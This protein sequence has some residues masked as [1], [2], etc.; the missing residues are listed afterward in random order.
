MLTGYYIKNT[1]PNSCT[2]IYLSQADPKGQSISKARFL[3]IFHFGHVSQS[4]FCLQ[5]LSQSGW[6]TKRLRSLL[7]GYVSFPCRNV[8]VRCGGLGVCSPVEFRAHATGVSK[9]SNAS[10][11]IVSTE[12][13]NWSCWQS[14]ISV[15]AD[16]VLLVE[17]VFQ[18]TL[19]EL[20][21]TI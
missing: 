18:V 6:S 5:A 9:Q 14:R 7:H 13:L 8:A 4:L 10:H 21:E 11:T 20:I 1:G 15:R 17:L 19:H 3:C 2:F 16:A 12:M